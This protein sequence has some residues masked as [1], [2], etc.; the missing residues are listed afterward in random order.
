MADSLQHTAEVNIVHALILWKFWQY[1]YEEGKKRRH[2]P[3]NEVI[4]E[5]SSCTNF[6]VTDSSIN[7]F[8]WKIKHKIV[9]QRKTYRTLSYFITHTWTMAYLISYILHFGLVLLLNLVLTPITFVRLA[10]VFIWILSEGVA[11]LFLLNSIIYL[12]NC[13]YK[14]GTICTVLHVNMKLCHAT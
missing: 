10:W 11:L 5:L 4:Q 6:F 2:L 3:H 13:S 14:R 12:T 9:K 7:D 8:T 1:M